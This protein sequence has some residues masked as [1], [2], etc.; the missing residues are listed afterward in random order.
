MRYLLAMVAV[1]AMLFAFAL[2]TYNARD[3]PADLQEF[4][5]VAPLEKV[6]IEAVSLGIYIDAQALLTDDTITVLLTTET[7]SP[8][9]DTSLT[10]QSN[11]IGDEA[12]PGY[13]KSTGGLSPY[14]NALIA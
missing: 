2:S 6:S 4:T 10:W 12:H 11:W 13:F 9:S 14:I 1:M 5:L 3:L 8:A 7:K